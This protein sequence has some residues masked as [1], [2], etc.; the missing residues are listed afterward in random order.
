MPKPTAA[1]GIDIGQCALKAMRLELVDGQPTATAFDYIEHPKILS[2]PDADPDQLTRE[3][4]EKFLSRN[5]LGNDLVAIGVPGQSGLARFVKLPPVEP[6]KVKDIVKFEAKQQIPFPLDEVVWDYQTISGG[7]VINNFAMETEIGLFAMK[8]EVIA[9]HMGQFTSMNI[10]VHVVQMAPLALC[11]YATYELLGKGGPTPVEAANDD[12]PRGKKRCVV[13]LDVGTDSSNLI[14]T[15]AGKIIWQRPLPLGGNHFTRA[16]TKEMKLTFAKAEHLK[17]NAAKSPDLATILKSLRPVLTDFVGE[18]QRSL[19]YFTNTHRDAHIAYLVGLGSAFRLP[20]LQKYMTEKLSLDVKR[21]NAV[22]RLGGVAVKSDPVFTDNLLSFPVAYGLALQGL[23]ELGERKDYGRI[24]TNLLPPQIKV[25]RLIR[26][27]K[28][29]AAA[30]AAAI[31]L[32]IGGLAIGYGAQYSSVQDKNLEASMKA[33]DSAAALATAQA[34]Q[35]TAGEADVAKTQ[36]DVKAIIKGNDSRL[37]MLRLNEV[38][39][40]TLPRHGPEGNL[41]DDRAPLHQTTEGADAY[42]KYKDRISNGVTLDQVNDDDKAEFLA[43][44]QIESVMM[45]FT[46]NLKGFLENADKKAVLEGRNIADTMLDAEKEMSTTTP[47]RAIP[48]APDGGGWVVQISGFTMHEKGNK[49]LND[50]LVRNFVHASKF[51]DETTGKITF[52]NKVFSEVEFFLPG[53]KDPV[54]GRTS[55][56]FLLLSKQVENP[57][58]KAFLF[59]GQNYIDKLIPQ[60]AGEGAPATPAPST[61]AAPSDLSGGVNSAGTGWV[62]L[63]ATATAG[64]STGIAPVPVAVDPTIDPKAKKKYRQEFVLCFV[65]RDT[66]APATSG[67]PGTPGTASPLGP[68]PVAAPPVRG[69]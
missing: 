66:G 17:R 8:K 2:Q 10:E 1:W 64:P 7:E 18:V 6:S 49:F 20:G 63:G 40:A 30:A 19:G 67:T 69:N 25:D 9:K 14:I 26:S 47:P 50:A 46:D 56:V 32:G 62:P 44:V 52:E 4:L 31:L 15:D 42:R 55:H 57:Q 33:A 59:L 27:K 38:M 11:N 35:K 65:W 24:N 3:S 45:E 60:M 48:K 54:K 43:N 16:L 39:L 5:Q 61:G 13:V 53:V 29:Y 22:D 28:P 36:A 37:D 34:A 51:A 68:A 12:T 41:N 21:P 23:N 58:P